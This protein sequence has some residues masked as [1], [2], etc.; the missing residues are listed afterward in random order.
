[1]VKEDFSIY[2]HVPF[3][4]RKCP[5][6]HF[7]SIAARD[8]LIDLY[9][10]SLMQEIDNQR[11]NLK[12]ALSIY[13]G[14]GTPSILNS[15]QLKSI[16]DNFDFD[17]ECEITIEANPEIITKEKAKQLKSIGFNRVSLGAQSFDENI[18]A[19]LGRKTSKDD[20]KRSIDYFL[21]A[22][23]E[24][25][26]I[27]LMYEVP[28]QTLSSWEDTLNTAASLPIKH[29]SLY[30]L[31][32]EPK[33]NFF[34]QRHKLKKL[35]CSP[36]IGAKMFKLA[37]QKLRSFGFSHYEISAFA[38]KTYESKHNTGYWTGRD[39]IGFG[40]AAFSFLEGK[41]FKNVSDLQS[42]A[43]GVLTNKTI[44]FTEKLP[45][46]R[47]IAELLAINLR[48]LKGVDLEKFQNKWGKIPQSFL[49]KLNKLT[50]QKL[51]KKHKERFSLTR[52]G[53]FLYDYIASE[54]I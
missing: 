43:K 45:Y 44:D 36:E 17:T 12:K 27:D 31:T 1:M 50:S 7:Y 52:R 30:N 47:N 20:I 3:C 25:I 24:N 16:L 28:T 14:G 42:Y 11:L 4:L 13:F 54:I 19:I 22:G 9:I 53:L 49:E 41:R 6:C 32:I 21:E 37:I 46:P 48:L 34:R 23:I 33:T 38:K 29:I 18:L 40:P 8:N 2:I 26:S 51:L 5:Y 39:F 10:K 15:N 35:T